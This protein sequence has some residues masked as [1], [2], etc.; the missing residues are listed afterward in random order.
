MIHC[1]LIGTQRE[2]RVLRTNTIK[3]FRIKIIALFVD[4]H[5]IIDIVQFILTERE[6]LQRC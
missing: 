4:L 5:K 2:Q 3:L 1:Q 6:D